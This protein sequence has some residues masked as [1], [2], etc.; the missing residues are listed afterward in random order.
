[1]TG[2]LPPNPHD[3]TV[4]II[5]DMPANLSVVAESLE[6][7]GYRVIVAQDAEEGLERAVLVQPD[8][9]LLDVMM[10]GVNGFEACR[11]LKSLVR[12][13]DIPVVFMTALSETTDKLVG[14]EAGGVDYVTKPALIDEV[15]ARVRVHLSL[16]AIEKQLGGQNVLL[17]K[18]IVERKE[19]EAALAQAR[20]QLEERVE[21]RTAELHA[22]I[23]VR[24]QA[25][26]ALRESETRLKDYAE[27]ASDWFWETDQEGRFTY[28]S[29]RSITVGGDS[30]DLIGKKPWEIAADREEEAEKWQQHRATVGRHEPFRGFTYQVQ[31]T[32]GTPH[33]M[34]SG[35][36]VFGPAGDFLGYRGVASD[37]TAAVRA[38]QALREAKE[39]QILHQAQRLAAEAERLRLL[40]RLVDVQEQERL[41]IA[42]EL[43]DQMGQDLTGL[44][45]G[46]KSLENAIRDDVARATLRWLQ[47]LTAQIGSN[48][49]RTAWELRP[50]SLD[51][52]GLSRALE[53]YIADW[54]ERFGKH[55]DFFVAGDRGVREPPE[56]ETTAYRLVQE[57]LTNVVKHAGADSVSIVLE[58]HQEQLQIVIE[59][60]GNGFDPDAA[61]T[62]GR[63]GLAGMRE[64]LTLVGGSLTIDSATGSGTTL[65][66]RIPLS[67][68]DELGKPAE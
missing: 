7:C 37:V 6:E 20:D 41:R 23:L 44:S 14:F 68:K 62:K 8:L 61:S 59:D 54:S 43:H 63:L 66:F 13:K 11:R 31:A 1:V 57:G 38:D 33:V 50:T 15:L 21:Q 65:Y 64:R 49:H 24:R 22:E 16:R 2:I 51:D 9:I 34:V 5:D 45:L 53:T 17:H 58:W 42:R 32:N 3:R 30:A 26:A 47:S 27:T 19:A 10:P 12:T 56:V 25:E 40:Q 60:D 52:V 4:L 18:E 39:Q 35:K 67:R 36:P 28:I 46:L 29:E 48:V 55:A